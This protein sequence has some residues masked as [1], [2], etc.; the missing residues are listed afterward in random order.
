MKKKIYSILLYLMVFILSFTFIACAEEKTDNSKVTLKTEEYA[1]DVSTGKSLMLV[2]AHESSYDIVISKD[3]DVIETD[4][5]NELQS[6]LYQSTGC[7]LDVISD[8]NVTA[9]ETAKYISVGNT[10]LSEAVEA[11][12]SVLGDSGFL[13]DLQ[14]NTV[15]LKGA[16]SEGTLYAVYEFLS[17]EIGFE[18]YA[19]DEIY[20]NKL[21]NVKMV[22]FE[23]YQSV[24][25]I[26]YR[27]PTWGEN[28]E[29]EL[30]KR[31]RLIGSQMN[32]TSIN[33]ADWGL[34]SHSVRWVISPTEH[35]EW[36]NNNHLCMS[37][38]EALQEFINHPTKGILTRIA[39]TP[40]AR[41]FELGHSD[42]SNFCECDDCKI[43]KELYGGISGIY[44]RWL[45]RIGEAVENWLEETGSDREV[46]IIGLMYLGYQYAPVVENQD[47]SFS[48]AHESVKARSNVAVRY[49]PIGACYA[50]AI[51]DPEC[52]VNAKGKFDKEL[53]K[54]KFVADKVF[55]WLYSAEYY[56]Y[57]FFFNDMAQLN[58]SYAFYEEVGVYGV[59]DEGLIYN[60][61]SPFGGLKV[62]LRSKLM[63]D[64]DLDISVLIDDFYKHYFREAAPY[65]KEMYEGIRNHFVE[66]SVNENSGGCYGFNKIGAYYMDPS[67][68][69]IELLFQ[70]QENVDAAYEAIEKAGYDE[71][72]AEKLYWRIRIDELFITHWYVSTY[73]SYFSSEEYE[74]ISTKFEEDCAYLGIVSLSH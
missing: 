46:W 57:M 18:A 10:K 27:L 8:G 33:G 55:L 29:V 25:A 11:D 12:Y 17:K 68:W 4:A 21:A 69:V 32:G 48:L 34:A 6:F 13:I 66:I 58:E 42:D 30:A 44:M 19:M 62:Y 41:F 7:R 16:T 22:K 15:V 61:N 38:E 31:M 70:F 52:S 14:G 51:N 2:E 74:A 50:H 28:R 67:H 5:A 56:D 49:A 35:P 73:K 47:G 71:A 26:D 64:P 60:A 1:I 24:A 54:W 53:Q 72:T 9:N 63:W 20:F 40:S 43:G 59:K 45:N 3:A 65:M 39:N 37:N 36:Y 23:D